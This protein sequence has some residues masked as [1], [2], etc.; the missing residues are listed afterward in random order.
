MPP[1]ARIERFLAARHSIRTRG[2]H[3]STRSRSVSWAASRSQTWQDQTLCTEPMLRKNGVV[4]GDVQVSTKDSVF[5]RYSR[6]SGSLDADASLPAPVGEPVTRQT[7][8]TSA[9]LGYTRTLTPSFIN[10]FRFTWTTSP[11]PRTQQYRATRS[12]Q[13]AWMRE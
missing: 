8:S 13:A 7:D 10:E 11:W 4:R 12:S 6:T 2:P 9:G 1:P 3:G 5:A